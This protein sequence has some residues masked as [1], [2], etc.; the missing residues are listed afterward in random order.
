MRLGRNYA[1]GGVLLLALLVGANAAL[2]QTGRP[3]VDPP[4]DSAPPPKPPEPGSQPSPPVAAAPAVPSDPMRQDLSQKGLPQQEAPPPDPGAGLQAIPGKPALSPQAPAVRPDRPS[5]KISP[6]EPERPAVA[7]RP[8][9]VNENMLAI[10]TEAAR[11]FAV[12][13]LHSWS[14]PND[15]ALDM[16]PDFYAPHVM[17]HGRS[18]SLQSLVREKRRFVERW[19]ERHYRVQEETMRVVCEPDGTVCTVHSIFDFMAANPRRAKATQGTGALQLVLSF[20]GERPIITAENSTVLGQNG[21][22]RNFALEGAS[23]E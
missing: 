7:A 13:Y 21:R 15:L 9:D 5:Q 12:T 2:A 6:A 22:R 20:E 14:A 18:M 10:R 1:S 3:W 16:T 19:P 8:R 17:F 4:A 23:D 11:E